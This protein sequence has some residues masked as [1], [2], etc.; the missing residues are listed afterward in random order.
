MTKWLLDQEYMRKHILDY[1]V[2]QLKQGYDIHDIKKALVKHGYNPALI[3]AICKSVNPA[4]YTVT[5]HKAV[6]EL[7]ADLYI[8]L[9]NLLVDYIEKEL[10]QGYEL[11]VIRKALIN[12]GHHPETV[13][14]AINAVEKGEVDDLQVLEH[15]KLPAGL[16]YL[17]SV[18]AILAL[19]FFLSFITK[20]QIATVVMSFVPALIAVTLIYAAFSYTESAKVM[21]MLPVAGIAL[22][23]GIFIGLL[24][25][26]AVMQRLSEPNM[27]L[28]MDVLAVFI[29]GSLMCFF[30]KKKSRMT[31]KE[32]EQSGETNIQPAKD[33]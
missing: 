26:S 27:I 11:E 19:V 18:C 21:Q 3:D 4:L 2:F 16:L 14:K 32:I 10:H 7:D 12:Y 9:Q 33:E 31:V 28:I 29:L 6:K 15:W 20:V 25:I 13:A 8:Y 22:T 5:R 17:I 1:V 24:Q 30:G 23:V